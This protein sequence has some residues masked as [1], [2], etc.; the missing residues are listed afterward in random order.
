M[1]TVWEKVL[2]VMLLLLLLSGAILS[3]SE[4]ESLQKGWNKLAKIESQPVEIKPLPAPKLEEIPAHKVKGKLIP[5]CYRTTNTPGDLAYKGVWIDLK[6]PYNGHPTYGNLA[7]MRLYFYGKGYWAMSSR[8]GYGPTRQAYLNNSSVITDPYVA[9]AAN[10]AYT[11]YPVLVTE[12]RD[13][14]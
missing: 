11:Y 1:T 4:P 5:A 8:V 10:A 2:G 6:Q 7:G 13:D 3:L 9:N 14:L 12:P